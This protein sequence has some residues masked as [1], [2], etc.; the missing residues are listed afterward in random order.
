MKSFKNEWSCA[1][2]RVFAEHRGSYLVSLASPGTNT[3]FY[4][5]SAG[6]E[7]DLLLDFA[8]GHRNAVEIKRS[9]SDPRPS[10]GFHLACDDLKVQGRWVVYPGRAR[11]HLDVRTQ[12]IPFT[13]AAQPELPWVL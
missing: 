8:A 2:N 5:T 11:F 10:K 12:A 6:A 7:I 13:E 3:W 9:V 4:R 1:M